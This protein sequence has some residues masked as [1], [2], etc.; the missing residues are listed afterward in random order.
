MLLDNELLMRCNDAVIAYVRSVPDTYGNKY[1]PST[2][3]HY[4]DMKLNSHVIVMDI[5]LEE[6][7]SRRKLNFKFKLANNNIYVV[8]LHL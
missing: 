8:G 2:A 3:Q 6:S 4:F 5:W 1:A 7:S